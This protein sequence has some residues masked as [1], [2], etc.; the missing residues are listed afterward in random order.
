MTAQ[1]AIVESWERQ[2]R[3]LQNLAGLITH[4]L[5]DAK[6]SGDG[7]TVAYHLCHVHECRM[8]WLYRASGEKNPDLEDLYHQVG[9]DWFPSGDIDLN[10]DQL[11]KS[12]AAVKAY[13]E[14]SLSSDRQDAGPYDHP[15]LYLQHMVWHEGY[16]YALLNLALRLAG[17]EPTEEWEDENIWG[18]WRKGD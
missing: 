9:D 6:P 17:H 11:A 1:D 14:V 7:W 3:C 13:I 10:R 4:E 15:I 16:H 2:S 18:L 12:E 8:Y 5:L